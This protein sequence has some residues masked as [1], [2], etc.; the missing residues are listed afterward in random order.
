MTAVIAQFVVMSPGIYKENS[1]EIFQ[2]YVWLKR[3]RNPSCLFH[4]ISISSFVS[5][6]GLHILQVVG[7]VFL[8]NSDTF[9]KKQSSCVQGTALKIPHRMKGTESCCYC[10]HLHLTTVIEDVAVK[11][12]A[13]Y[14]APS[15][16][17]GHPILFRND[18]TATSE[19]VLRIEF[20]N[21]ECGTCKFQLLPFST[22]KQCLIS[23]SYQEYL[24]NYSW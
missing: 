3:E 8:S 11:G 10:W 16:L 7:I 4:S 18:N 23:T 9:P 13:T 5:K 6:V 15:F 17:T 1:A 19:T 21:P 24:L 20:S 22:K 14:I 12:M 2:P